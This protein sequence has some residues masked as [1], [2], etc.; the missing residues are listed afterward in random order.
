MG[1]R[2]NELFSGIMYIGSY[3]GANE[4]TVRVCQFDGGTAQLKVIQELEGVENASYLALH[5]EGLRLYA[6]SETEKVGSAIGGGV[7]AFELDA[8]TGRLLGQTSR[9][10]THGAHPC[11]VST[12]H[13]GKAL[14]VANYTGGNAAALPVESNGDLVKEAFVVNDEG[15]LGPNAARQ[16]SPHAHCIVPIAGTDFVC[17]ADLGLD[18]ILV[19]RHNRETGAL[20]RHS[21]CSV[22]R[23]AGPR[24]L[25]FHRELP[26]AYVM[27]E[28]DSTITLLRVEEELGKL[29]PVQTVSALPQGFEGYNDA[30]DIHLAPSGRFLYSSNRGHDS[31]AVLEAAPDSG[32]LTLVQH[33]GSGGQSPRNFAIT[34][35]GAYL[36][37]ANQKSG[38]VCAFRVDETNGRL[39]EIG[40][41]LEAPSP[42]FIRIG[43]AV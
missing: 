9:A 37:A 1:D 2:T 40:T 13:N 41:V 32:E 23:G 7:V 29:T 28:L 3:G 8:A 5:P 14:F 19:Y 43:K 4:S 26:L 10:L 12:D 27:N 11:Y 33:I 15:E 17:V 36:L 16:D 25:V 18:A 31:I 35:D 20:T 21:S 24:H 22:H 39:T 38:N 34:P 6:V 30:A 42:V